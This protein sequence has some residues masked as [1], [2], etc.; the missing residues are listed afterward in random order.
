[1][2]FRPC[3]DIHNGKVKQI[4]GGSLSDDEDAPSENFVSA[5]GADFFAGFFR[6]QGLYGGHVIML[7]AKDS[8]YYKETKRQALCALSAFP[9]GL[10]AGGGITPENASEFLDAGASHVIVTSYLFK[11]GELDDGRLR[12]LSSEVGKD[13]LVLDLSCRKRHNHY[14][15]TCNR[16]QT[17]TRSLVEPELFSYLSDYC[18]EFLI[19]AADIE[20]RQGGV[21]EELLS[22]L[23]QW[24]GCPVTY[25]GGVAE[26]DDIETVKEIGKGRID[27]TIGSALDLYGGPLNYETVLRAFAE[28]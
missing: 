13:R 5:R 1:M 17:F 16:W 9:G 20:G 11:N 19:H 28:V 10:Q 22:I 12:S 7:N 2:K 25:A 18:S 14:Y 24:D 8:P 21:D 6:D 26:Y 3:I 15:V 27:L 4:V 23:A